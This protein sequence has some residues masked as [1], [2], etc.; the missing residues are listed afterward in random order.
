MLYPIVEVL[1]VSIPNSYISAFSIPPPDYLRLRSPLCCA[2]ENSNAIHLI[3]FSREQQ[4][5]KD[6]I[7]I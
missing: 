5:H 4:H 6:T 7:N 1:G 3:P 2:R